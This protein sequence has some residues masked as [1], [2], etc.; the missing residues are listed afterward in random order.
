MRTCGASLRFPLAVEAFALS[1]IST[2]LPTFS[3]LLQRLTRYPL[4]ARVQRRRRRIFFLTFFQCLYPRPASTPISRRDVRIDQIFS[5]VDNVSK[6]FG[7]LLNF[8]CPLEGRMG[9]TYCAWLVAAPFGRL[10]WKY[11]G[12]LGRL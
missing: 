4:P 6:I 11:A 7:D 9:W 1:S 5:L 2:V 10:L 3:L 12:L 8:T